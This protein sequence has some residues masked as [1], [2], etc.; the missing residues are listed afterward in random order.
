MPIKSLY[1]DPDHWRQ[2]GEEMRTIA[3]GMK[4]CETK[5]RMLSIA[6]DYDK[7]AERAE[8]RT[9]GGQPRDY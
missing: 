6:K 8:T 3:G 9:R 5:A 4:E 2:R 7:L 1:D